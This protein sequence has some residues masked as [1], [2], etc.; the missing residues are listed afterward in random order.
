MAQLTGQTVASTYTTLLKVES[1][2]VD[3]T[4]K[5][6]EDGGG[7]DS[8]LQISTLGVKSTGTLVVTGNTDLTGTLGVTG[9][10]TLGAATVAGAAVCST[11][12]GVT[13]ATTL[14]TLGVTGAATLSSTLGVTG[15]ATIS[16]LAVTG[17]A[18]LNSTLAVAS[19]AVLS[20][21]LGVTGAATLSSTLG[22]TGA[23]TLSSTANIVGAATCQST[24]A[25]TGL[26]TATG[27]VSGNVTG[28]SGSCTGNSATATIL[29]TTRN[30]A[31]SGAVTGTI[32]FNGSADVVIPTAIT[33]SAVSDL[34]NT[35][36]GYFDVP[37]GTTAERPASPASGWTRYNSTTNQ[38]EY[39]G[40]EWRSAGPNAWVTFDGVANTGDKTG[41]CSRSLT[42]VTVT[43][44]NHGLRADDWF[45][46]VSAALTD[47][48]FQVNPSPAPTA[49]TFTYTSVQTGTITNQPLTLTRGYILAGR[50]VATVAKGT[51][52]EYV[53]NMT[54]DMTNA[55]YPIC[56]TSSQGQ[57]SSYV[58]EIP[59]TARSFMILTRST[60]GSASNA[61]RVSASVF[62]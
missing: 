43:V 5:T 40:D 2:P 23:T 38:L 6:V 1:Q 33:P 22:V 49:D 36:T 54:T 51:V 27:G 60:G 4:F 45:Y 44:V 48:F 31:L 39:Y 59:V 28:S 58:I 52:G 16:T 25:V 46:V 37:S 10:T 19:A 50:G 32:P 9:A 18:S 14:N 8:A 21:T 20:N 42:T 47:G 29:Q 62:S 41:L 30:I 13:G 26:L 7:I 56:L 15:V 35:S 24:L 11:T 3:T 57:I 61:T 55:N 17:A 34:P 12:L 53:V